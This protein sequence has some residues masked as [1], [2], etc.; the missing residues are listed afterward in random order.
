MEVGTTKMTLRPV[1]DLIVFRVQ[2][3][4]KTESGILL[5]TVE[6]PFKDKN[7]G[8]VEFVGPD[9]KCCKI[10]DTILVDVYNSTEIDDDQFLCDEQAVYGVLDD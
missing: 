10:G 9:V 4:E 8:V 3:K 2:K 5:A 7:K 6:V 1:R